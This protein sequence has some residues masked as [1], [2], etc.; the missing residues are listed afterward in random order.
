MNTISTTIPAGTFHAR[1]PIFGGWGREEDKA[2]EVKAEILSPEPRHPLPARVPTAS[3]PDADRDEIP[4]GTFRA[5]GKGGDG[6][7]E[8][9]DAGGIVVAGGEGWLGRDGPCLAAATPALRPV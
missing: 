4:V 8:P 3:P 9:G 1:K 7:V 6:Q 2:R 5:G